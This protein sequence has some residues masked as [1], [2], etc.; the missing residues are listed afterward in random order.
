MIGDDVDISVWEFGMMGGYDR[1]FEVWMR[2]SLS[3][4]KQPHVLILDPGID[5]RQGAKEKRAD[6]KPGPWKTPP[7]SW[8]SDAGFSVASN[9]SSRSWCVLTGDVCMRMLVV[10]RKAWHC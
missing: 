1:D 6:V 4:P 3:L 2:N 8:Y 5:P 9:V 10:G 7:M